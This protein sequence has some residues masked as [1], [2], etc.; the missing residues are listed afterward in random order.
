MTKEALIPSKTRDILASLM[1][2]RIEAAGISKADLA[3]IEKI[4]ET[5][6]SDHREKTPPEQQFRLA[7]YLLALE[8]LIKPKPKE[9]DDTSESEPEQW[10]QIGGALIEQS[11]EGRRYWRYHQSL[12]EVW[13]GFERANIRVLEITP[14]MI[15]QIVEVLPSGERS[16]VLS[17]LQREQ[18]EEINEQLRARGIAAL[19]AKVLAAYGAGQGALT[20]ISQLLEISR[21]ET[22]KAFYMARK[23]LKEF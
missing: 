7:A 21:N 9:K 6:P 22:L 14:E 15:E 20:K 13:A 19:P 5:F 16:V 18:A 2:E 12:G 10:V 1:A 3:E 17:Q 4:V 8:R 11:G 23:K